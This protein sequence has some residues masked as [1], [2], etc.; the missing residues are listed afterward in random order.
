M[1]M[2]LGLGSV[3]ASLGIK[4]FGSAGFGTDLD[5]FEFYRF[6]YKS[7]KIPKFEPITQN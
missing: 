2:D 1:T 5:P 3:L 7:K 4:N 6:G